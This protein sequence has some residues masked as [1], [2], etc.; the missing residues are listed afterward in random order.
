MKTIKTILILIVIAVVGYFAYDLF[1][2]KNQNKT[3]AKC[4]FS[5]II[6]K[7]QIVTAIDSTGY[8][9]YR[10]YS[11]DGIAFLPDPYI[12]VT[13][14]WQFSLQFKIELSDLYL[15]YDESANRLKIRVVELAG[16]DKLNFDKGKPKVDSG[17]GWNEK[18]D[19]ADKYLGKYLQSFTEVAKKAEYS[20]KRA[21]NYLSEKWQI[22]IV[23]E[24]ISN[25]N[26]NKILEESTKTISETIK[27]ILVQVGYN[28][29]ETQIDVQID[30]L[31]VFG[32]I[33][34]V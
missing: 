11:V 8:S 15:S 12:K 5:E 31:I 10:K 33:I 20:D 3:L 6:P 14:N 7:K 23:N 18:G 9:A 2:K 17:N 16:N 1:V 28:L 32:E 22:S 19:H 29:T 30:R 34:A 27:G 4:N 26:K 24:M 13:Y 21:E 25:N